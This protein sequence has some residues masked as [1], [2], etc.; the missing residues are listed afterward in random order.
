MRAY[1]AKQCLHFLFNFFILLCVICFE[2]LEVII[3]I[4]NAVCIA[5]HLIHYPRLV[6]I[7]MKIAMVFIPASQW[8]WS[9]H[10]RILHVRQFCATLWTLCSLR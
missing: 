9:N 1:F 3:N 7:P 2:L 4:G 6:T 5:F 8:A 10:N